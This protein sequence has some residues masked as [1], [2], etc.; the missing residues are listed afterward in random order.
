M[1][2][3]VRAWLAQSLL[4]IAAT[5]ALGWWAVPVVVFGWSALLPRAGGV[6][7]AALAGASAWTALL[8]IGSRSGRIGTVAELLGAIVGTSGTA[9][10]V[11]TVLYGAL[12]A[13]S[14]ALI[15]RALVPPRSGR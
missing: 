14:A 7:A 11:L 12:L 5:V 13:G 10:L 4:C 3:F 8:A 9:L 2:A 6:L 1:T 15:A